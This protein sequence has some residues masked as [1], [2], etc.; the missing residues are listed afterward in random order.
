MSDRTPAGTHYY[1]YRQ[2]NYGTAWAMHTGTVT[3]NPGTYVTGIT[4]PITFALNSDGT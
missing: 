2:Q 1:Q 3:F 4:G